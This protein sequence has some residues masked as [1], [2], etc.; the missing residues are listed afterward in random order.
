[1]R[2]RASVLRC[3][4]YRKQCFETEQI[5]ENLKCEGIVH[6]VLCFWWEHLDRL[7]LKMPDLDSP[8]VY[9]REPRLYI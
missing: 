1:M 2:T 5:R 9:L 6:A 4:Y 7:V 8:F 3:E